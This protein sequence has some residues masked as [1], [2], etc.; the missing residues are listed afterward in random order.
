M[1]GKV[2]QQPV[3]GRR[4]HREQAQSLQPVGAGG[5]RMDGV[6]APAALAFQIGH[7]AGPLRMM[8]DE[9]MRL[10]LA[11]L[12]VI[13]GSIEPPMAEDGLV[14]RHGARKQGTSVEIQDGE[15]PGAGHQQF[16]L[17]VAVEVSRIHAAIVARIDQPVTEPRAIWRDSQGLQT[18]ADELEQADAGR[19]RAKDLCLAVAIEVT[20]P[21]LSLAVLISQPPSLVPFGAMTGLAIAAPESFRTP[22][23]HP[24]VARISARPSPSKSPVWPNSLLA[25]FSNQPPSREPFG[26]NACDVSELLDRP[27]TPSPHG[28]ETRISLKLSPLKSLIFIAK[29]PSN[30]ANQNLLVM[31][32]SLPPTEQ[33]LNGSFGRIKSASQ[34]LQPGYDDIQGQNG[35]EDRRMLL[36]PVFI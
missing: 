3:A 20:G 8:D 23:P 9:Q 14:R 12:P 33:T 2:D 1:T 11:V 31:Y 35:I 27:M 30:R 21:K 5:D 13:V 22:R 28:L 17:V 16:G 10:A 4:V 7:G 18:A 19:V 32:V 24:L 26:V 25:V 34:I 15:T 36:W 6:A 29:T